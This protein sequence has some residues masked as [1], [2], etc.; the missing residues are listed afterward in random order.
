MFLSHLRNYTELFLSLQL[1]PAGSDDIETAGI[2]VCIDESVIEFHIVIIDKSA[3]AALE[4]EKNIILISS[5]QRIIE[6]ADDIVSAGS[7]SAGEDNA[8][9]LLL[10]CRSIAALYESDLVLAVSIGEKGLDLILIR[11]T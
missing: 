4:S 11:H 8:H 6:T 3:G 7:L 2:P 10:C 5:L 9:Y 1:C